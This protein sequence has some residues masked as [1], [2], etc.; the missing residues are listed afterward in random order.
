[1]RL[2]ECGEPTT[3]RPEQN[4]GSRHFDILLNFTNKTVIVTPVVVSS[5]CE[6]CL[7]FR[8]L[9]S[10]NYRARRGF[11][12]TAVRLRLLR[13]SPKFESGASS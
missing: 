10:G 5:Q 9:F 2:P 12:W 6:L 1:M 4:G 8:A 11:Q 13:E 7:S 3:T